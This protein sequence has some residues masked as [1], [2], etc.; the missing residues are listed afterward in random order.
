MLYSRSL[1]VANS[2]RPHGLY[3][4]MEFSK[5]EYWSGYLFPSPGDLRNP[6]IKPRWP[7]LPADSLPVEPQGKPKDTGVGSPSLLQWI[8]PTQG[9]NQGLLHCRRILYQL[10]YL[11]DSSVD[12][13]SA[14][15]V[16]ML[17]LNSVYSALCHCLLKK[18]AK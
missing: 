11:P 4:S 3:I 1:L 6:G 8:F 15:N 16:Y 10:S 9:S 5:P 2:L 7:T 13:E 18:K 12:K 14:C 17:I